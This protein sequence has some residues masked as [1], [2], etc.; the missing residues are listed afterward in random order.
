M[1]L[2]ALELGGFRCERHVVDGKRFDVRKHM[3][4]AVAESQ[5]QT[6]ETQQNQ[7]HRKTG[8]KQG[9]RAK[10]ASLASQETAPL[11]TEW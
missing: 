5:D 6:E 2:P 7:E 10:L 1:V 3:L 9:F 8:Q 11:V 4:D